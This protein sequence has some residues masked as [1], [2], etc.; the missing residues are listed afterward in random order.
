MDGGDWLW[1]EVV[2]IR[3]NG[4]VVLFTKAHGYSPNQR[5]VATKAMLFPY[6]VTTKTNWLDYQ[7]SA[8]YYG[9]GE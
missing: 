9:K 8:R 2:Q 4:F 3:T 6:G 5:L 7:I 1:E